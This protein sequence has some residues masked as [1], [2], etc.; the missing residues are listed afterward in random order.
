MDISRSAGLR[1]GFESHILSQE[2]APAIQRLTG[3]DQQTDAPVQN[4]LFGKHL[5]GG[6]CVFKRGLEITLPQRERAAKRK[7]LAETCCIPVGA[8]CRLGGTQ[9]RVQG[10]P[11]WTGQSG[12]RCIE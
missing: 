11:P 4:I 3:D 10:E 1:A 6:A 5:Q 8:P 12:H 7:Q 2:N 9:K